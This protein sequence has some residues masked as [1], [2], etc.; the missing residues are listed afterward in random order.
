MA[1]LAVR[2]LGRC[3]HD[4]RRWCDLNQGQKVMT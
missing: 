2:S 3:D 4:L 1:M